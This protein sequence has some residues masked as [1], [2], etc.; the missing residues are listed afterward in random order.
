MSTSMAPSRT[1][2][3]AEDRAC[4]RHSAGNVRAMADKNANQF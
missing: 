2:P 1:R 4:R 3:I